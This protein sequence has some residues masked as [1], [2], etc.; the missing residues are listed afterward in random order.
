MRMFSRANNRLGCRAGKTS[1][2]A[3]GG[4]LAMSVFIALPSDAMAAKKNPQQDFLNA[5]FNSIFKPPQPPPPPRNGDGP[6]P[7]GKP[8]QELANRID[9]LRAQVRRQNAEIE[10]LSE[11]LGAAEMAISDLEAVVS[12]KCEEIAALQSDVVD[13]RAKDEELMAAIEAA[14]GLTQEELIGLLADPLFLQTAFLTVE[15]A[16]IHDTLS[17]DLAAEVMALS[18]IIEPVADCLLDIETCVLDIIAPVP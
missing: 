10:S 6:L 7:N 8:F 13:L 4:I 14:D 5:L 2:V 17:A 18:D 1:I 9:R 16:E 11:D 15:F 3:L 12:N